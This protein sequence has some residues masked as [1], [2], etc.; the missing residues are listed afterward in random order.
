MFLGA[1]LGLL[2][3]AWIGPWRSGM[4]PW[5]IAILLGGM[6]L[7]FGVDGLNSYLHFFPS[8]TL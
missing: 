1:L 7:A 2:F 4:P 3:Q 8:A 5:K 6:A